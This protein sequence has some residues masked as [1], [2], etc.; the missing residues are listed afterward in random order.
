MKLRNFYVRE[1]NVHVS[2]SQTL[3]EKKTDPQML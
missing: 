3:H 1:K 2:S